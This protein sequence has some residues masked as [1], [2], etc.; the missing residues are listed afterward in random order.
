M[1][2]ALEP[3]VRTGLDLHFG[4]LAPQAP[5]SQ[6]RQA[7]AESA[8]TLAR[9]IGDHLLWRKCCGEVDA[10]V[11]RYALRRENA[12]PGWLVNKGLVASDNDRAALEPAMRKLLGSTFNR[13]RFFDYVAGEMLYCRWCWMRE[14]ERKHWLVHRLG[15][16]R[17]NAFCTALD[18][19]EYVLKFDEMFLAKLFGDQTFLH[20]YVRSIG[21][22]M[23]FSLGSRP[24]FEFTARLIEAKY[25]TA[26]MADLF[27]QL[28]HTA[29]QGPPVD[30]YGL[31]VL[32]DLPKAFGLRDYLDTVQP[33]NPGLFPSD[34]G[35]LELFRHILKRF[36]DHN[37]CPSCD[38]RFRMGGDPPQALVDRIGARYWLRRT[39]LAAKAIQRKKAVPTRGLRV[40][41]RAVLDAAFKQKS[42][43]YFRLFDDPNDSTINPCHIKSLSE[44]AMLVQSPR[45]NRL[46]EAGPGQD[47][48]GYFSIVGA[49]RKSTY[50]DFRT[51]VLSVQPVDEVYGLVEIA[52]PAA[53]ELTRRTHKRLS[54]D[55]GQLG[56]FEMAAPPFGAD[57]AQYSTMEK[58]PSPFC[59]IPDS[60]SHCHI[61][62]LSAGG[63]MLEI[64]EDAPAFEYFTERNRDY[65]LLALMQLVGRANLPELKLGL[66][67]DIK[68]IRD[69][70]PLHKKYV[71]CQFT[72]AGEI[73]QDRLVRFSPVGKDGIFLITD[74]IFR[75]TVGH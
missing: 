44:N 65:P 43:L 19:P 4:R 56:I 21:S 37:G 2:D 64:H 45:G 11:M 57:W 42:I 29:R 35:A 10:G 38:A 62:D 69:F 31:L 7:L 39:L 34:I 58:W 5:D 74:W 55:P 59:I 17:E 71:G 22:V 25:K 9:R 70:P 8:L 23:L 13:R 30:R 18:G 41:E 68:R 60:A 54:L 40:E 67:L 28:F 50:L 15:D 36:D 14:D 63:L 66:R 16:A 61:K 75:N 27:Q 12:L 26:F 52:L 24:V 47:V 73:R 32:G 48:H 49:N 53:F 46:N 51:T 3:V 33:A 20:W 1:K 6:D 72:E